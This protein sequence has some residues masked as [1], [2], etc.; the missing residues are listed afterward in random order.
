MYSQNLSDSAGPCGNLARFSA[1]DSLKRPNR[2]LPPNDG[3]GVH[4]GMVLS[5]PTRFVHTSQ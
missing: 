5:T 3:A 1:M 4:D 2:E